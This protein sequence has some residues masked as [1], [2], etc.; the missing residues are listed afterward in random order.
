MTA[1]PA[2]LQ[3]SRRRDARLPED[4]VKVDRSTV[5]GN[6]FLASEP[7]QEMRASGAR[8]AAEAFRLWLEGHAALRKVVPHRRVLIMSRLGE[9]RGKPLACWCR[10]GA[11]CHA[12]VLL[13]LANKPEVGPCK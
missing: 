4:A 5:W 9:L 13:D 10:P 6:P 11:P 8:T 2:R 1:R 3:L 7:T 12:D